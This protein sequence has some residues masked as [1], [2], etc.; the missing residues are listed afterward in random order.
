MLLEKE[1]GAIYFDK[2]RD[3]CLFE[4]DFNWLQ[5]LIF[6]KQ[7]DSSAHVKGIIPP[8]QCAT[9]GVDQSQGTML[10]VY[11]ND[12]HRTVHIPS[13]VISADLANCYDAVQH[14]VSCIAL[15]GFGVPHLA[16]SMV[17]MCLQTMF[18]WLRTAFG[19]CSNP[20]HSTTEN[21][22]FGLAQGSGFALPTFQ[23]VSTLMINAYK[24]MG[25]GC[26]YFFPV[27][28]TIFAFGAILYVDD[29]EL[30]MRV[31]LPTTPD[32]K[33]FNMIQKLLSNWAAIVMATGASI[34]QKK[35]Y[36]RI[37]SYCF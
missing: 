37:S 26:T 28:L 10:K 2:L 8:E 36:V 6:S 33:F 18:F 27:T 25:N 23:A 21:P 17:L 11:H 16:I 32:M 3:I 20:F 1:F 9:G 30:L 31:Q 7:M 34:K 24:S 29:T 19:V 12:M 14:A 15:R 13:V 22:F 5:K 4:A 35:S